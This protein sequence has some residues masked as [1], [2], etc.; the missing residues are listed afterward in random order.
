MFGNIWGHIIVL[1]MS[2]GGVLWVFSGNRDANPIGMHR[3][4]L[5]NVAPSKMST[6]SRMWQTG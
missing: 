4:V 3:I 1:T 6:V 5:H 2:E